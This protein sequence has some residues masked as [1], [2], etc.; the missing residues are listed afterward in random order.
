MYTNPPVSV[1]AAPSVARLSARRVA[2][3]RVD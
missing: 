2:S 3:H 1:R